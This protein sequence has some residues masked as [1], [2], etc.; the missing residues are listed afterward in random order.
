MNRARKGIGHK[1][2]AR[3]QEVIQC[4]V[5]NRRPMSVKEIWKTVNLTRS[6]GSLMSLTAVYNAINE[7]VKDGTIKQGGERLS[8]THP[9]ALYSIGWASSPD[10]HNSRADPDK[11][12]EAR[13]LA[14]IPNGKGSV[15][16]AYM[17]TNVD[18]LGG[19]GGL[20]FL[21]KLDSMEAE[22]K[23]SIWKGG[24]EF[25]SWMFHKVQQA[26]TVK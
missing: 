26:E 3:R 4:L 25:S 22:G 7:C 14:S 9:L 11:V 15:S 8:N 18:K 6:T 21:K 23:I 24:P 10:E 2:L 13:I 17:K 16:Y 12:L 5:E 1:S 20:G 19:T